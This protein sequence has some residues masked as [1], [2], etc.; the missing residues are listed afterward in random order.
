MHLPF[1]PLTMCFRSTQPGNCC[2]T[3]AAT[4][5]DSH[6]QTC[7]KTLTIQEMHHSHPC[8]RGQTHP[9]CAANNATHFHCWVLKVLQSTQVHQSLLL[10][11]SHDVLSKG[12]TI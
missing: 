11:R 6:R 2:M 4:P 12:D 9:M 3:A 5:P 1:N 8:G 10:E 7:S